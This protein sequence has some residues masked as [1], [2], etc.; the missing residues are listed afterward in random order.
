MLSNGWRVKL[1]YFVVIQPPK[2]RNTHSASNMIN[3][4]HFPKWLRLSAT[5]LLFKL[6]NSDNLSKL[7]L[8]VG[9]GLCFLLLAKNT[10][11]VKRAVLG[12]FRHQG[13]LK[14]IKTFLKLVVNL[15]NFL[16]LFHHSIHNLFYKVRGF[17]LFF[18]FILES[19]GSYRNFNMSVVMVIDGSSL[20]Q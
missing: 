12:A 13:V 7:R 8:W 17:C 20:P 1:W 4:V 10:L 14:V 19:F 9:W 11:L 6:K 2:C 15:H 18:K 16:H 5:Y 3:S